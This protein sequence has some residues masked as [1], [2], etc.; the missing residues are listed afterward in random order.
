MRLSLAP[1][2]L[3][4]ACLLAVA[5]CGSKGHEPQTHQVVIRSMQFDPASI[6]VAV[7]DVVVW[8]NKDIVPHTATAAG[9]FDSQSLTT[10]QE[11]RYT[12][13]KPGVFP[14]GCIFHPTMKGTLI[15]H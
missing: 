15:V 2:A 5:A 4:L 12:A 13:T 1:E 14:Y 9:S 7:G 11:W 3:A 10:N 6:D 8:V